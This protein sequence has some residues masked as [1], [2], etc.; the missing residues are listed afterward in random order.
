VSGS[1]SRVIPGHPSDPGMVRLFHRSR[2]LV[3]APVLPFS[4]ARRGFMRTLRSI[5]WALVVVP[6]LLVVT[7][8]ENN[9]NRVNTKGTTTSP[10]AATS[11]DEMLKKGSEPAKTPP[12]AD[13]PGAA[14]R[15]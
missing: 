9:E 10:E 15:R 14:R 12:P 3:L 13:Y 5:R 4:S 11:V 8:C 6:A 1:V 7:G 2:R